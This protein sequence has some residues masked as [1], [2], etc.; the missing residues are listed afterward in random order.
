[1]KTPIHDFVK[2]Y[3]NSDTLRLHM[4]G[5]KGVSLLGCET[6]DITEITGADSLYH[7]DG[8][9]LESENYASE[10][11]GSRHTYYSTEGSSLCI[12]AILY[13]IKRMS[14]ANGRSPRILAG[15]NAHK[16]FIT[17]AALLDMDVDWIY[18]DNGSY[19]SCPID[20]DLLDSVLSSYKEKP[21]AVYVTSPDYLGNV[22]DIGGIAK[23]CRA[24]GVILA[25]DNAHGAY[26]KFLAE[27]THPI[28]LGAHICC[29][30]AHKT[31]PVLTGGAYMHIS[32]D[33]PELFSREARNA[34]S[35]FGSTSP[36]YLI[37]QSLD[38]A[39][40]YISGELDKKL[41][42]FI[43]EVNARKDRLLSVG[44]KLCA[45]EADAIRRCC[46]VLRKPSRRR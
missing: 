1:M 13:L 28:D 8:I 21:T 43:S 29:D 23:V 19:L 44:Y 36:S 17:A 3:V 32:K 22:A 27:S 14:A 4:P 39:N 46:Q 33:A 9:I 41:G 45:T 30:S 38:L 18:P 31:L 34:L 12:R 2:S 42:A 7:A 5:H 25:V 20:P 10:L 24:H 26:L 40:K 35:I 11:F 37:L 15:R 16:T 6:S